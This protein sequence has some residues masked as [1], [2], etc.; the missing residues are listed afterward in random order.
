MFN[1]TAFDAETIDPDAPVPYMLAADDWQRDESI[2]YT[3]TA[4]AWDA[5]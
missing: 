3:P 1:N 4:L 2:P 5:A